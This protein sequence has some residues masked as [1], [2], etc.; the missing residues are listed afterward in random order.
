MMKF[1]AT[2]EDISKLISP[3]DKRKSFKKNRYQEND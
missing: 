3:S 1:I 2:Y